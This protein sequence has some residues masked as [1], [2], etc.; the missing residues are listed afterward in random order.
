MSDGPCQGM[1]RLTRAVSVDA[2]W[3]FNV[4]EYSVYFQL[5]HDSSGQVIIVTLGSIPEKSWDRSKGGTLLIFF[6]AWNCPIVLVASL[7][8]SAHVDHLFVLFQPFPLLPS[9]LLK[10]ALARVATRVTSEEN[11]L[12]ALEGQN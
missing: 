3:S 2:S 10:S 7:V 6:S 5:H 1:G 11:D 8:S 12:C 9:S 4:N